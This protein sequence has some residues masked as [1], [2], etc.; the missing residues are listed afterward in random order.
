M[1]EKRKATVIRAATTRDHAAVLRLLRTQLREHHVTTSARQLA[2]GLTKV[3]R[4]PA[5]GRILVATAARRVV[6]F[7]AIALVSTLEHGGRAAWLEEL[8]VEPAHREDGVGTALL[9][10][11]CATAAK[12]G[13]RAV[14]LEVD[15]DHARAARLYARHGFTPLPRERWVLSLVGDRGRERRSRIRAHARQSRSSTASARA[16]TRS[17]RVLSR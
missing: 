8:Y 17:T 3:M 10:A 13:A 9:R 5:I 11:A 14:D 2:D 15:R 6:G 12:A 16:D 4:R 7:A 1:M